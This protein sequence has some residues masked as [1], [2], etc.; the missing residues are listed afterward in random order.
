MDP[1][2]IY[3]LRPLGETFTQLMSMTRDIDQ[4]IENHWNLLFVL[5]ELVFCQTTHIRVRTI[6]C[7]HNRPVFI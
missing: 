7:F 5:D 3:L 4:T 1:S 2:N 6:A